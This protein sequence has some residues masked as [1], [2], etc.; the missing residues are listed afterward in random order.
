MNVRTKPR[1]HPAIKDRDTFHESLAAELAGEDTQQAKNEL[2]II[3]PVAQAPAAQAPAA[4]APVAQV[5]EPQAPATQT[6]TAPVSTDN[7]FDFSSTQPVSV[8]TQEVELARRVAELE[9]QL[10]VISTERDEARTQLAG[11][12]E[13][14]KNELAELE[15]LRKYRQEAE[16]RKRL[17]LDNIEFENVSPEVAREL[18]EKVFMP[19]VTAM[20]SSFEE[21]TKALNA[22][23]EQTRKEAEERIKSET[24]AQAAQ[25]YARI[26]SE[27]ERAM[28]GVSSIIQSPAF[29]EYLRKPSGEHATTTL[30]ELVGM[31]YHKG[32]TAYVISAVNNFMNGRPNINDIA[33]APAVTTASAPATSAEQED[34]TQYTPE[35]LREMNLAVQTGKITNAE[36]REW[37][38]KYK[39]HKNQ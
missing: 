15:E 35:R 27:L 36:Y 5:P 39:Q 22:Q 11:T 32:N 4:Q 1:S 12:L 3:N 18:N 20:H 28:P 25:R 13:S 34:M 17:S 7:V 21:K 14:T 24:E 10:E 30:G 31:E 9:Q 29:R 33:S 23:L 16:L 8:G 19:A 6:P 37:Y 26:N 2:G 38:G